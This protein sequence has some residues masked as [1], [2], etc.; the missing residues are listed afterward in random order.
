M[1][2]TREKLLAGIW[3]TTVPIGYDIVRTDGKPKQIILNA[4]GKLIKYAFQW[5]ALGITNED[6]RTK[7]AEKGLKL[8]NQRVSALIA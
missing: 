6:I 4:K 5:K 3:C 2:G 1:S 8:S 7:L